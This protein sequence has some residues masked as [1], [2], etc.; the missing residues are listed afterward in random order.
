MEG[1]DGRGHLPRW[2]P[3]RARTAKA[4]ATA[5]VM[6]VMDEWVVV[7]MTECP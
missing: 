4:K 3:H 5:R 6:V 7:G 1:G 2:E